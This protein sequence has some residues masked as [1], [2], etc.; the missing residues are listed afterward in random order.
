MSEERIGVD[1]GVTVEGG[2][3][4]RQTAEDLERVARAQERVGDAA[5]R[6]Q[7]EERQWSRLS[8][9][10]ERAAGSE[11]GE[12]TV[13][14]GPFRR[15]TV[16]A[17][18][19][20]TAERLSR[21]QDR[22]MDARFAAMRAEESRVRAEAIL[23]AGGTEQYREQQRVQRQA[24]RVRPRQATRLSA[25]QREQLEFTALGGFDP[26][27]P[28]VRARLHSA[29]TFRQRSMEVQASL[30]LQGL[31]PGT[32]FSDQDVVRITRNLLQSEAR[33]A[34]AQN[35]A[36]AQDERRNR[37]PKG[38]AQE[39]SEARDSFARALRHGSPE[40][41]EDA[42][43]RFLRAVESHQR[44]QQFMSGGG[45][46]P[47]GDDPLGVLS[48]IL[49]GRGFGPLGRGLRYLVAGRRGGALQ[50]LAQRAGMG[51]MFGGLFGGGAGGGGGGAG[52][53]AAAAGAGGGGFVGGLAQAVG[54]SP[55]MIYAAGV[56]AGVVVF[57][58]LLRALRDVVRETERVAAVINSASTARI[59]TGGAFGDVTRLG[60][61]GV[62]R[63]RVVAVAHELRDALASNQIAMLAGSR[64]GVGP[65]LPRIYGNVNEARL[66]ETVI[67]RLRGV[68]DLEER[69]RL[70][71]MLGR[72]DLIELTLASRGVWRAA[73]ADARE[74]RD[75][76]EDPNFVQGARDLQMNVRRAQEGGEAI[77]VALFKPLI[78]ALN[79]AVDAVATTERVATRLFNS[80]VGQATGFAIGSVLENA[81]LPPI[82]RVGQLIGRIQEMLGQGKGPNPGPDPTSAA[83]GD[84]RLLPGVYGGGTR[85]RGALP[86][87]TRGELL[88]KALEEG[89]QVGGY[90]AL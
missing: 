32:D 23:A 86:P 11:I 83:G 14:M 84:A 65:V 75:V 88:R 47:E 40:R 70:A 31:K 43:Y 61:M 50:R 53:G 82:F 21:D 6:T 67:E 38:P 25:E 79:D 39:L 60:L 72:E 87:G 58:G 89:A 7:R 46:G 15:A 41:V 52:G 45:Q 55:A 35:R 74:Y 24:G 16:T 62:E 51:G 13:P 20:R 26:G 42:R 34:Q 54:V 78:P 48:Y 68:R 2:A 73:M 85:F 64:L 49:I 33:T 59:L 17:R 36:A 18:V 19:R 22:V 3:E 71:A 63:N 30:M 12:P 8:E 90:W 37:V 56:A 69:R 1:V 4:V 29:Q 77:R 76:F 9:A 66:L 57:A 5:R 81:L 10:G 44:A 28:A 80:P 27:S